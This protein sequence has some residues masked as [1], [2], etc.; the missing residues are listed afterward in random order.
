MRALRQTLI[1][2][3]PI[4]TL[5]L[6]G[7]VSIGLYLRQ[8]IALRAGGGYRVIDTQAV[9][10]LLDKGE[11]NRHEARWYH[12]SNKAGGGHTTPAEQNQLP[13]KMSNSQ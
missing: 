13:R 5:V 12:A 2:D 9:Q 8:G 11:L 4:I 7:L 10:R 6:V 1:H 3:W